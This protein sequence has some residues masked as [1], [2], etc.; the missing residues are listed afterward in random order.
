MTVA[1]HRVGPLPEPRRLPLG[2][3]QV[4]I[5]DL[6]ALMELVKPA[7]GAT[8]E[9]RVQFDGGYLTEAEDIRLL[10]DEE[11]RRLR[12]LGETVE[13]VLSDTQTMAIGETFKVNDVYRLWARTRQL[14]DVAAKKRL[15]QTCRLAIIIGLGLTFLLL[16]LGLGILFPLGTLL[17][18]VFIVILLLGTLSIT[19]ERI[20][21]KTPSYH[22]AVIVPSSLAEYRQQ[23]VSNKWP[24][25]AVIVAVAAIV[26]GTATAILVPLLTG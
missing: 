25:S 22:S 4:T 6:A 16:I 2:R 24:K 20:A 10:S 3:L 14:N 26:V 1:I 23:Q 5:D 12:V 17:I 8:P 9:V 15:L 11:L 18:P 7:T 19:I 21:R 13:V